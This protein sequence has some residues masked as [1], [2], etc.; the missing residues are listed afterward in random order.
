MRSKVF[1]F[2]S[3]ASIVCTE[4]TNTIAFGSWKVPSSDQSCVMALANSGLAVAGERE[5]QQ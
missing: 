1:R 3:R 2:F 4:V 5:L